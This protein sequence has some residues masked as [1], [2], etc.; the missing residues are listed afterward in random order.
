MCPHPGAPT[1]VTALGRPHF[2]SAVCTGGLA[3][4]GALQLGGGVVLQGEA[5]WRRFVPP[6]P[7]RSLQVTH[8]GASA[9]ATGTPAPRETRRS[10]RGP[11]GL[12]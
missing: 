8:S 10:S 6:V 5:V 3:H 9:S 1:A 12:S 11:R 2:P 4:A 7:Q